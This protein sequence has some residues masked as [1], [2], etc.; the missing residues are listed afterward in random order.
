MNYVAFY[1]LISVI[2][3]QKHMAEP[4]MDYCRQPPGDQDFITKLEYVQRHFTYK[5]MGIGGN[6]LLCKTSLSEPVLSG[7]QKREMHDIIYLED[8]PGIG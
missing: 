2:T 5:V 3:G 7:A 1:S 4:N 6:E 8:L